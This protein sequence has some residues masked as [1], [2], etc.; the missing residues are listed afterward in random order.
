MGDEDLISLVAFLH[1]KSS[2][3][4]AGRSVL[5]DVQ[6]WP[7]TSIIETSAATVAANLEEP[8]A[9]RRQRIEMKRQGGAWEIVSIR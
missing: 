5:S 1:D 3:T 8:G 6:P 4:T 2:H 7:L 9:R